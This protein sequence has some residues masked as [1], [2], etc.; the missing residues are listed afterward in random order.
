MTYIVRIKNVLLATVDE[1]IDDK[2]ALELQEELSDRF[3]DGDA[4]AVLL[5]ISGLQIVDSFVGRV[6]A[7]TAKILSLIGGRTILVGMQPAVALTLVELGLLLPDLT[8]ALNVEHALEKLRA[9]V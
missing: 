4:E 8:T 6:L 9:D 7:D 1:E 3:C 5:D 2:E